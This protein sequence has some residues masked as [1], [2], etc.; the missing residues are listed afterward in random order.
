MN[1]KELVEKLTVRLG[2]N[3]EEVTDM[4]SVLGE[5]VGARLADNDS[6]YLQGLGLFE[7]K[8]RMERISVSPSNGKRYLVPP[9]LIPVFKPSMAVRSKLKSLDNDG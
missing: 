5:M 6:I 1:N 2:W 9:K 3:R 4:L 8:K 7:V